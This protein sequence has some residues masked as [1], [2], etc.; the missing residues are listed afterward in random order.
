MTAALKDVLDGLVEGNSL[1]E[2]QACELMLAFTDAG[3]NPAMAGALLAALRAKGPTPAEVR[4]F[5]RGMRSLARQPALPPSL[6]VADLVGPGGDGPGAVGTRLCD[7]VLA[8]ED[9]PPVV[10]RDWST[11]SFFTRPLE[12]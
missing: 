5:A 10:V 9:P 11:A 3:M 1:S 4:G 6:P 12:I 2:D 7:I 8:I